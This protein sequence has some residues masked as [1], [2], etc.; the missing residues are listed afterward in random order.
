MD[1]HECSLHA[2]DTLKNLRVKNFNK[3]TIGTLNINSIPNKFEQLKTIVRKNLDILVINETK[4]DDNFPTAQ[5]LLDGYREP[6]R[7]DRTKNGGGV[8]VYVKEDIPSKELPRYSLPDDIEGIFFEINLRKTK[9]LMFGSYHPPHK[10]QPNDYFLNHLERAMDKFLTVYSNFLLIGDFNMQEDDT[11]L[12][13]FLYQYDAFNLVKDETCFKNPDNPSCIDLLITNKKG[14]FQNTS[15]F[16]TGLSDFHKMAVT[17]LKSTYV[18]AKPKEIHYR[19]Y[20]GFNETSFKDDLRESLSRNKIESYTDFET[21]FLRVLDKHAPIKCKFV[22][23]NEA[24]YMTKSLRKAIMK[25]SELET[26]F[27]K[28]RTIKNYRK[29]RKHKNFV[30]KLYKKERKLFY[31][32][33]DVK[34]V[35]DT[36]KFWKTIKPFFTDKGSLKQKI[37]LVEKVIPDE[38]KPNTVEEK[39]IT[40]DEEVADTLNTFFQ[41]AV[42]NLEINKNRF[43]IDEVDEGIDPVETAITKYA[44]HPSILTIQE[45]IGE[46]RSSFKFSEITLEEVEQEVSLLNAKKANT[47]QNIPPKHLKQVSD[48]CGPFL[49]NLINDSIKK[50]EFPDKLKCADVTPVFKKGDNTSV[51]NYR[52]VSVLPVVSKIYERIMQKQINLHIE[53]Y[54]SPYL[55][56]YRKRYSTQYALVSLI[57]RWKKILDSNGYAGAVLMD[58][59]K[60]F[61]TLN[62]ELLIAKLHA[63]GFGK[64]AL[65]LI[66][67]YLNNRWQRTKIDKSFSTWTELFLGV[68][69]GSVLGPL[70]FNIYLNDLFW[71]NDETYVCNFADDTTFYA[72]DQELESVLRR[73]EHDSLL[74]IEWFENNYMKLNSDKCHLLISGFKHQIHWV[75][76]GKDRIWES[77]C[78][79][80]LGIN[81]DRHL[82][83]NLHVKK[84][85]RKASQ[86]LTAL[87]RLSK[88]L[89]LHK[90]RD[91]FKAFIESQFAYCPL[92]W[93]FHDR[94]VNAKIDR[95]HERSLRLVYEDYNS[96][97]EELL[98]KDNSVRIHNRNVQLLA[99]EMYKVKN[100]VSVD[101]VDHIFLENFNSGPKLRKQTEFSV[102][103]VKSVYNG[104]CSLRYLGPVIWN[105]LPDYYK[106]LRSLKKFKEEIK[107]W[108]PDCPCRLCKTYIQGVG[109]I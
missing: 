33:L 45:K 28:C 9:W 57:E 24:P 63:Y 1:S 53:Q 95:L 58:L 77:S 68:P 60:A 5:F 80:L 108:I 42:K 109:F 2:A 13:D 52:P 4:L 31:A 15:V 14:S 37:T 21:T 62:H 19:D 98:R 72:C 82:R 101:A 18:K 7:K 12:Y 104:D 87:G 48:V 100:A 54:L 90:R 81:I 8:L 26:K 97:F 89:P 16:W 41:N 92:V 61:D 76:I 10:S 64:E 11:L 40:N 96:T 73:L 107:N 56:G 29:F 55:C 86:K 51:E 99:I 94:E 44:H 43:L 27:Y 106:T 39:I 46:N 85:C 103:A 50:Q 25:R 32:N 83:F 49:L 102:P 88:L 91:L 70:L 66:N 65:H 35:S 38:N 59:S 105:I 84:V 47:F 20:K 17:V 3:I 74:A 75:D 30:S 22:R 78:E 93:F 6:Y 67:G 79:K 34:F 71:I 23:A 36:K 69:Q